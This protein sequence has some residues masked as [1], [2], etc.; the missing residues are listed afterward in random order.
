MMF[1]SMKNI[2]S[3]HEAFVQPQSGLVAGVLFY[4]GFS[5]GANLWFPPHF[6]GLDEYFHLKI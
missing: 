5:S 6:G 4:P 1:S 2:C 3:E